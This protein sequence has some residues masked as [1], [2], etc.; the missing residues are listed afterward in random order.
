MITKAMILASGRGIRMMPLTKDLPKPM[1][2]IGDVTLLEDKIIRLAECGIEEII[3]NISYLGNYISD[4][5]GDGSKYGIKINISN[6]GSKP[7][8]T[9]NGIRKVINFFNQQPFI[10][11]NADIWTNYF[12]IDLENK[13]TEK[14]FAHIVL[15]DNPKHN[16]GDF[17]L[18][19]NL[20]L[21]GNELTFSGIGIYKPILF[22]NYN[23]KELGSI[24]KKE[25]YISGE[26]YKGMWEDIGTP[27]RLNQI[28][29]NIW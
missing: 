11:V 19:D 17:N 26:Y 21:P 7:I 20:I 4:Y 12:Y 23:D 25:K 5:V 15:V 3:I 28:R 27:E 8:G 10:V 16:K 1:L 2:K 29:K 9:A 6:E 22:E 14:S 18:R 13:L 24:L